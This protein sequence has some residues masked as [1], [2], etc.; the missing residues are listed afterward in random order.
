MPSLTRP[1]APH[2]HPREV[3]STKEKSKYKFPPAALPA[4]F[5]AFFA[6][7]APPLPCL[8]PPPSLPSCLQFP[9]GTLDRTS[10][11]VAAVGRESSARLRASGQRGEKGKAW[12]RR[13][14]SGLQ[15]RP[16]I[17]R[18]HR[19][20]FPLPSHLL[21]PPNHLYPTLTWTTVKP[22]LVQ[23]LCPWSLHLAG[24]LLRTTSTLAVTSTSSSL[25]PGGADPPDGHLL[26]L[27]NP[28]SWVPSSVIR[29]TGQCCRWARAG[30]C[31]MGAESL[32]GCFLLG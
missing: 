1:P 26:A 29:E 9:P 20:P 22:S 25:H 28:F 8:A 31:G 18:G 12:E 21:G 4:E 5:G 7:Q 19:L 32:R 15:R 6:G 16:G 30:C 14:I 11:A 17:R 2:R 3:I 13:V 24:T 27:G 10:L 23:S